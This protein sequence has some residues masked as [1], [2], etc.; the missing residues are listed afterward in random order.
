M[1]PEN[2]LAAQS[3]CTKAE[4]TKGEGVKAI[5]S[6]WPVIS[7][8]RNSS[9]FCSTKRTLEVSLT[10]LGRKQVVLEPNISDRFDP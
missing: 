8:D 9:G 3:A 5:A 2:G 10:P 6:Y 1:V 7:V 4:V